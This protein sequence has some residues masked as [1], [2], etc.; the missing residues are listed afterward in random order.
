MSRIRTHSP[1]NVFRWHLNTFQLIHGKF[2]RSEIITEWFQRDVGRIDLE[3]VLT[4]DSHP[5]LPVVAAAYCQ[6]DFTE[7]R[8]C[9]ALVKRDEKGILSHQESPWG[10]CLRSL[11]KLKVGF[12]V[13]R[14]LW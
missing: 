14:Q 1:K 5:N 9:N 3:T 12:I 2:I 4:A 11:H 6:R 8:P 13:T 10:V 7:R